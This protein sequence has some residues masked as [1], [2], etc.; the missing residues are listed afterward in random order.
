MP[1]GKEFVATTD[2]W[3]APYRGAGDEHRAFPLL[4]GAACATPSTLL[5]VGASSRR[6]HVDDSAKTAP[7]TDTTPR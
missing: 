3:P 2:K 7:V 6:R 4:S 5:T 1:C